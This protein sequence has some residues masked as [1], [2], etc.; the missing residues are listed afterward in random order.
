MYKKT[1]PWKDEWQY[2]IRPELRYRWCRLVGHRDLR[3]IKHWEICE[4]NYGGMAAHPDH[5]RGGAIGEQ[6]ENVCGWCQYD[7]LDEN[8]RART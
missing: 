2:V 6:A 7:F 5:G 4:Y 1:M 8:G 3:F